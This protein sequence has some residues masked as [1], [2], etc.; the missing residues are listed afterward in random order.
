MKNPYFVVILNF[1]SIEILRDYP[2]DD[3]KIGCHSELNEESRQKISD[4]IVE[5]NSAISL[6]SFGRV[7]PQDDEKGHYPD[8]LSG[9][10]EPNEES[11]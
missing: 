4:T 7:L 2:Q 9:H 10:S 8:S 3:R 6:R 1:V 5:T 11:H